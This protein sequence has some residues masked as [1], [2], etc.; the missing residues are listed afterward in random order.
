[1]LRIDWIDIPPADRNYSNTA[2]ASDHSSWR[3]ER[4]TRRTGTV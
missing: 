3:S 2:G 1:V 4:G